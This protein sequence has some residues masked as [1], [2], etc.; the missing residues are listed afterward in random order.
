MIIKSVEIVDSSGNS[1]SVDP[2]HNKYAAPVSIGGRTGLLFMN[3]QFNSAVSGDVYLL[4]IHLIGSSSSFVALPSDMQHKF[5]TTIDT[6]SGDVVCSNNVDAPSIPFIV[7][8]PGGGDMFVIL[9]CSGSQ[10]GSSLGAKPAT[11][12]NS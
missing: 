9:N 4:T 5:H 6:S 1:L 10:D 3:V 7:A 2:A 8:N 12:I 11:L